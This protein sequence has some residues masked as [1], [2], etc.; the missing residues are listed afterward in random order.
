MTGAFAKKAREVRM[1]L[2]FIHK[3]VICRVKG[4][5]NWASWRE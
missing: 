5:A 2:G 1:P 4:L 3:G